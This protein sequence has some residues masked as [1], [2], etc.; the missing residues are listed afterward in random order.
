D[1]P[2][3]ETA[4][5]LSA[6]AR[7]GRLIRSILATRAGTSV[8]G[9]DLGEA[10]ALGSIRIG[11]DEHSVVNLGGRTGLIR[12]DLVIRPRPR[13]TLTRPPEPFETG[14]EA[15]YRLVISP[16]PQGGWNHSSQPVPA[17]DAPHRVELWHTRLGVREETDD[18]ATVDERAN[19][20][21][22][23]RAVWARDREGPAIFEGT[24]TAFPDWQ[25]LKAAAHVDDPFRTSLDGADRHM[26]VRQS[27]ETW[28]ADNNDLLTPAPIDVE[29][30]W[31]SSLG[32]WLDLYGTWTT[33]PYSESQIAS[34][35]RWDHL[36][37]MG[38]DQYVRVMYPGYLYP[39]GHR[40][41]LVKLTERK[42][43]DAAPSVAGLYQRKFLAIS[44]P[45]KIYAQRDLPFTEVT[46][47]PLV[48]PTLF[49]DPGNA[50]NSYFFPM[51]DSE[52]FRFV[53][54]CIDHEGRQVR[55]VTP[56]LW[57]AEHFSSEENQT[58]VEEF[59]RTDD[60]S[61]VGADGQDIA[62]APVS[63]GGDTVS[64]T[65]NLHF[66]GEALVGT[67][68]PRLTEASVEIPVVQ[69]LS[70]VDAVS[71]KYSETYLVN[72]F[73]GSQNVGEIWAELPTPPKLSFGAN[74]S[75]GS[76][77]A[78]G[79]LQPNLPIAGLSRVKG[80][81]GE[82]VETAQGG[83]DP[84]AFLS[85]AAPKLFGIVKLT[86]LLEAAGVDLDDAPDVVSEALDRIEGLLADLERAKRFVDE[87]VA[88]AH[89]L[90]QRA[91][92][93]AA[94]LQQQ[95]ADALAAAE[96]LRTTVTT[97]VNDLLAQLSSLT[98]ATQQ[99][100]TNALEDPL[101]NLRTAVGEMNEVAPQLPPLI[102][103][104]LLKLAELLQKILD[105]ADV[106][107]DVFRFLNGLATGGV[108]ATFRYE[109]TPKLTSWPD[110]SDP[111]L[112]VS[113]RSLVLAVDG[114][115]SKD[116]MDVEVLAELKDFTLHLL[117]GEPLVRFK[118][119]HLSF[120]A[121]SSGKPDVDVVLQDIEFVGLLSFV[122]T[123]KELIPFDGFSDP[124][125]LD[126]TPEG[127]SAGFSLGLPNVAVGVFNLSNISLGAD[128]QV[129]FLGKAVTVGFNFCTRERPFMLAVAFIGGGGWFLLRLS[130][131][132]LDV[133]ELGLE[134][135]AILAV[136]FG[137]ASGSISAMLG[138]YMRLEGD[139]GSLSGY[140]RLRGE[141]DVLGLISASIELYLELHYEFDTGKMV[142]RAQLTIK[143]EVFVFS[144]SVTITAERR[145]AGS[146]GDPTFAEVMVL[147][148]GTSPAWSEYCAAFAGEAA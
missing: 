77:R 34:I 142:G 59:Y 106:V 129:P 9:I 86:D 141:V 46:V 91:A 50:Q 102:R 116:G 123:L 67:S 90:Q 51:V 72:G 96:N 48:T 76:D 42:M 92:Q 63:K 124:P 3:V 85:G 38:R 121:G 78:G 107:E 82:I 97:A 94:E 93:K 111:I 41:T 6:L 10:G 146:A 45:M 105:A 112:E 133:L 84:V 17:K 19:S 25:D 26:L 23:I 60:A 113:E 144:A 35:L 57:V 7:E 134:A 40:A 39:F 118:F 98:G 143:V 135:G 29:A 81:V 132:G 22:I 58:E 36:A 130:P 127:M 24:N 30:L 52:R 140:F 88:E 4:S 13:P 14:I 128:V 99:Q 54:H 137:V 131:D 70:P 28:V 148:D 12:P 119:D 56:L 120:H 103:E 79:F 18:A 145:F 147:P 104:R 95:A 16:S 87:A 122:E 138:I 27:S 2:D 117:P 5:G 110:P 74:P 73:G 15:P 64:P 101:D 66:D 47:T 55:L 71:I 21:R 49:P 61:S 8:S 62:F 100:V 83:F 43:K 75:A 11:D 20:Q 44:E 115:A 33:L 136:D 1:V 126:V 108:Q 69:R 89:R 114:R 53:L 65:F 32:A 109:W 139:A 31:L 80:T 37:P 68:Q 125:F